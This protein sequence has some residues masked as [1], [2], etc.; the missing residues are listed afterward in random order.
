MSL[1]GIPFVICISRAC[2][3]S[4]FWHFNVVR[5]HEILASHTRKIKTSERWQIKYLESVNSFE[6]L[7][8]VHIKIKKEE[9]REVCRENTCE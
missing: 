9:N 5:T 1:L 3:L 4:D 2:I 7:A 8:Y 6:I